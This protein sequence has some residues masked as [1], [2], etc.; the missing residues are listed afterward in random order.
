MPPPKDPILSCPAP[1]DHSDI[2]Q[3]AHGG[4]GRKTAELI[5]R[6]GV[7]FAAIGRSEA[8]RSA[9]RM[10]L[11]PVVFMA[12]HPL[13]TIIFICLA[14]VSAGGLFCCRRS[15]RDHDDGSVVP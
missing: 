6:Y 5:E 1:L 14:V 15:K 2:V 13:G 4:G 8:L 7:E 10:A 11:G 3:L 12:R 9:T